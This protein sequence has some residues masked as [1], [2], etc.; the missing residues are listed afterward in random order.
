MKNEGAADLAEPESTRLDDFLTNARE[1]AA[2]GSPASVSIRRLLKYVGAE[3]RGTR[4]IDQIQLSL[5]EHGLATDP[6]FTSGWIDN[7]VSLRRVSEAS[8]ETN[9]P[10]A[11]QPVD[12]QTIPVEVSLTVRSLE[13]AGSGVTSIERNSDLL[14]ARALMLRYD[15]SQL[16]VVSGPRRLVGAVSWESMA[17]AALRTP[18]F[19]LSDATIP[20]GELSRMTT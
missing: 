4:V 5:D 10:A 7:V 11:R 12:V 6:P 3:R 18:A 16:A 8:L 1:K 19:A 15:Y 20:A 13:S 14:R 2:S 9:D 17:M